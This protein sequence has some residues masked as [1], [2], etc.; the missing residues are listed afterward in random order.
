MLEK[1]AT[2][3]S[4]VFGFNILLPG[5]PVQDLL[6]LYGTVSKEVETRF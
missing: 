4:I 5:E 2:S 3:I 1:N 6:L